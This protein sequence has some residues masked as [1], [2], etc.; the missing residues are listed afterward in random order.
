MQFFSKDE[1]R[2]IDDFRK[3]KMFVWSGDTQMQS[4]MKTLGMHGVPL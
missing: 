1:A 2:R 4:L 3:M